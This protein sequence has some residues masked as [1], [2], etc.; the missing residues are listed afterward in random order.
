[1][2]MASKTTLNIMV[3]VSTLVAASVFARAAGRDN[4]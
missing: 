1:M 3:A 4:S 2:Y